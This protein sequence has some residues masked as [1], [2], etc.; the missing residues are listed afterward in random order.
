[1]FMFCTFRFYQT[2]IFDVHLHNSSKHRFLVNLNGFWLIGN[3]IHLGKLLR[4]L[5]FHTERS[6]F[7]ILLPVPSR[8]GITA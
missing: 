3:L 4:T 7:F 6:Q 8:E 2:R 1:M 5:P